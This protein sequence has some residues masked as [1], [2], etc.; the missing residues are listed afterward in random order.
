MWIKELKG[1]LVDMSWKR[2]LK[3]KFD[4]NHHEDILDIWDMKR[5][6]SIPWR[7][8]KT[9]SKYIGK[10][11]AKEFKDEIKPLISK[12]ERLE[13]EHYKKIQEMRQEFISIRY[14]YIETYDSVGEGEARAEREAE[15]ASDAQREAS[16]DY[17]S[18]F[19]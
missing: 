8:Y 14:K 18:S 1:E 10:E 5:I 15:R 9:L 3:E 6:P 17:A 7:G 19:E 2:I 4:V 13:N 11:K 12:L 16:A